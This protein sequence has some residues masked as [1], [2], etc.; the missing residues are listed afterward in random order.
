MT[1]ETH[2]PPAAAPRAQARREYALALVLGAAAAGLVVLSARPGWARVR[3]PAPPPLH[4][5]SVTVTGQDLIPLAGA[6]GL[7]ALATLAA[8][9]ATR[10]LAR[11]LTGVLLAVF[12]VAAGV[13]VSLPITTAAVL[14]AA[15][16]TTVSQAGFR[17][18]RWRRGFPGHGAQRHHA[19]GDGDRARHDAGGVLAAGRRRGRAGHRRGRAPGGLAGRPVAG[20]V[21]QVHAATGTGPR[22]GGRQCVAVGGAEPGGR[23]HRAGRAR[24]PARRSR[25]PGRGSG[26]I[27]RAGLTVCGSRGYARNKTHG[28]RTARV[29]R[30]PRGRRPGGER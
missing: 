21:Q 9:I 2:R 1:G 6:L 27:T 22:S 16:V 7:A 26:R 4:A 25:W 28:W 18:R 29:R 8:V 14:A 11:R 5:S 12:G 30:C 3:T 15:R 20:H 23:S 24:S 19:G 10:G 17:H 13:A